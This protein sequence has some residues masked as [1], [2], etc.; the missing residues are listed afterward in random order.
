MR[1]D[2]A[3]QVYAGTKPI[4]EP[5]ARNGQLLSFVPSAKSYSRLPHRP[6]MILKGD[7]FC[8]QQRVWLSMA[9]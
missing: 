8:V 4:G 6:Q 3:A 7:D 2:L 9:I 1:L 5:G